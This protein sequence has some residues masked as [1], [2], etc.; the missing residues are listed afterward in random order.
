MRSAGVAKPLQPLFP[1]NIKK[2]CKVTKFETKFAVYVV[3][4]SLKLGLYKW[5]KNNY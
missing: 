2:G 4:K 3:L 5:Y 1:P